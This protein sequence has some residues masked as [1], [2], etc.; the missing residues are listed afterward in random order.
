MQYF[1]QIICKNGKPNAFR[2]AWSQIPWKGIS[3][4]I[5]KSCAAWIKIFT[6]NLYHKNILKSSQESSQN[7]RT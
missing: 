5:I 7:H 1:I 4:K 3:Q 2:F 6:G